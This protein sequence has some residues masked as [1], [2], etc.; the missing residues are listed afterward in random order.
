MWENLE[1]NRKFIHKF[2]ITSNSLPHALDYFAPEKASHGGKWL[3]IKWTY[4][5]IGYASVIRNIQ[6][7]VINGLSF[8]VRQFV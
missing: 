8:I 6:E 1:C 7:T 5:K 4:H 3:K 2:K